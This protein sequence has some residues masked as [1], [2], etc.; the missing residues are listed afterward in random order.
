MARI[1]FNPIISDISGSVGN[2]TFQR[3]L[4]GTI[5]K[6]KSFVKPKNTI[7]QVF[8][9][10]NM[11]LVQQAWTD[12][13]ADEQALW[14][15]FAIYKPVKTFYNK[16]KTLSGFNLFLKYNLIRLTCG[17]AIL[18]APVFSIFTDGLVDPII[19]INGVNLYLNWQESFNP[20]VRWFLFKISDIVNSS[21]L[22]IGSKVRVFKIPPSTESSYNI[23][24][25]FLQFYGKFPVDGDIVYIK[26]II[27][28]TTTPIMFPEV[29]KKIIISTA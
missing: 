6:T 22:N 27:F 18:D 16:S 24:A 13:T 20:S 12:L 25:L 4:G 10:N 9:Q 19:D 8:Q 15:N 7:F 3:S 28:D 17:L 11:I 2:A 21:V 26:Y 29:S 14:N 5:L 23:A 1:K